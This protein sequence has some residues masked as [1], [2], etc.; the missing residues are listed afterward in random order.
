LQLCSRCH[1]RQSLQEDPWQDHCRDVDE[2]VQGWRQIS[3]K[4]KDIKKL[5]Y[6]LVE[7]RT[8]YTI[9]GAGVDLATSTSIDP[10]VINLYKK[11]SDLI[12]IQESRDKVIRACTV[13]V[14]SSPFQSSK[15]HWC[16]LCS[17]YRDSRNQRFLLKSGSREAV[18][19]GDWEPPRQLQRLSIKG[20]VFSR[21]PRWIN[22]SSLPC[23]CFLYLSVHAVE[24]HDLDNLVRLTQLQYLKL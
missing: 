5:S 24:A 10:C 22:H 13:S 3:N 9:R 17:I 12:G 2:E 18:C 11:E 23:L 20:I 14:Q 15:K 7:L 6:Q 16:G 19:G 8:K 1:K 21:Q 4:V